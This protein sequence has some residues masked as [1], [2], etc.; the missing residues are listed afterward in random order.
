MMGKLT[1]YKYKRV[2]GSIHS[3]T[4]QSV[5]CQKRRHFQI[6]HFLDA[7]TG[8]PGYIPYLIILSKNTSNCYQAYFTYALN[9]YNFSSNSYLWKRDFD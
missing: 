6:L 5:I 3:F 2:L 1:W 9:Y 4:L 8:C 7:K